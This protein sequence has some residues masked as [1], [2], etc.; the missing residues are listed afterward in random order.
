VDGLDYIT[1]GAGGRSL[2]EVDTT[3]NEPTRRFAAKSFG[4][5]V[6]DV[7]PTRLV[8]QFRDLTGKELYRY[9]RRR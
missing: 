3:K 6:V 1:S 5:A 7:R 4:F 9:E 8:L 2:Y